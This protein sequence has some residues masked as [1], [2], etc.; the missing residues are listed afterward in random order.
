MEKKEE[1]IKKEDVVIKDP[2]LEPYFITSSIH[3][4]YTVLEKVPK[5]TKEGY[6]LRP[7][8]YPSTLPRALEI[9]A[10]MHFHKKKKYYDSIKEY[11][12]EWK[13]TLDSFKKSVKI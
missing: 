3:G 9:I 8:C 4:G 13:E 2:L 7:I 10:S 5:K 11:I 1:I 12:A 6:Y